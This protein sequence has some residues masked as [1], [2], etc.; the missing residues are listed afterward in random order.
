M[1]EGQTEWRQDNDLSHERGPKKTFD[2]KIAI[3]NAAKHRRSARRRRKL[4][5][6]KG[7][8]RPKARQKNSAEKTHGNYIL[9]HL[10]QCFNQSIIDNQKE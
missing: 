4:K 9:L 3:R 10:N 2:T 8:R 6:V 7:E 1:E 5:S